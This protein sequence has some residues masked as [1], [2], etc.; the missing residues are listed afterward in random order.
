MTVSDAAS[1]FSP[2]EEWAAFPPE[3]LLAGVFD[4]SLA[5]LLLLRPLA[6]P[7]AAGPV[8]DFAYAYLNPAAQR[9]LALPARPAG[10]LLQV[11]PGAAPAGVFDFYCQALAS[12]TPLHFAV[13]FQRQGLDNYY[14]L[15]ARRVGPGLLVSLTDTAAE[16]RTAVEQVLRDSQA[17]EQ[18]ARAEAETMRNR[19]YRLLME[20]PALVAMYR[21][22]EHVFEFVNAEHGAL[23]GRRPLLGRSVR[24]ALPELAGQPVLEL[25]EATY[26]TGEPHAAT[27]TLVQLAQGPT[28]EPTRN[29]YNLI[30]QPTRDAAGHPDGVLGFAYDVTA[31][32]QAR[33]LLEEKEQELRALN[34]LLRA[35][36]EELAEVNEGLRRN[37]A[38]LQQA[39]QELRQL[40]QELEQRV[41]QR[42]HETEA[43]RAEAEQQ[44]ARLE[45]FFMQAPAAICVLDG[46]ALVYELVNPGYQRLFPDRQ[47]LGRPLAEAMPEFVQQPIWQI[48][49][50]VY[51]TGTPHEGR[52]MLVQAARQ[53]DGP[54]EDRY[55]TFIYQ[56]RHDADGRIDGVLVFAYEVTAQVQARRRVEQSERELRLLSDAIPHLVWTATPTG[57]VEYCNEQWCAYT[58]GSV[59]QGLYDGWT[60]YFHPLDLPR[61]RQ[62]W[63]ASLHSGQ[64]YQVEARLRRHDGRYRWFLM[65]ALALR[66]E[67]G[68]ITRWFGTSTDVH[69]QK[70]LAE[71][72]RLASRKLAAT[73][74]ELRAANGETQAINQELALTNRQL[75]R[76]NQDLDN[77][78]YTASH[79]LRQPVYNLAGVFQELKRTATFHDPEAPQLMQMFEAA[80]GQIHNTIQGLSEV[81]QVER[82]TAEDATEPVALLPLAQD[83]IRSMHEQATAAGAS[84]RLE[85][86]AVPALR[87]SRLNL[88]SI[89]YNLLSNA[90][91]YRHP[92]RAPVVLVRT[93]LVGNEPVLLVQD[94]GLGIDLARFGADLFQLFRR[95]H[96]HVGG[97]GLGLYLVNRIVQ[98]A[99]GRVAVDSAVGV[100]TAFRITL[101]AGAAA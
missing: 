78:V 54:V 99:G 23:A 33:Q 90:L 14:R 65:R 22:P 93:E 10:T 31:Q 60:D 83:V 18:D 35:A 11:F 21:G 61:V 3:E 19:L 86:D 52:E 92:D 95:F 13:L 85:F 97:S 91:K 81:V 98:Q 39:E 53:P 66:D 50:R 51:Q 42:T 70:G 1:E 43:A 44:R 100:G 34:M 57:A 69:Q 12:P 73:N 38:A 55:F 41:A 77:F 15:A 71:A 7:G 16:P 27:E 49:Q 72:L 46:P 32:V 101:P 80:L 68:Q 8:T 30:Y 84:F 75:T 45:R 2:A 58:G 47:L 5:G 25:L 56:P 96:D 89:L 29:Y 36:N 76:I 28:G 20:A 48:L 24:E 26:R 88:Q 59:A 79:D 82:R 37:N 63:A 40:N 6:A 4:V 74:R 17:R 62:Q 64:P 87:C 9:I 94:N 67:Q